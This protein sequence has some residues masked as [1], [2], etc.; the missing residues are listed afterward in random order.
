MNLIRVVSFICVSICFLNHSN[1]QSNL[2][3]SFTHGGITREYKIY[4]PASYTGQAVPLVLNI[5]GYG[6]DMTQ[7]EAY[8][9]FKPIADSASFIIVHPNGT[10]DASLKRY[11]NFFGFTTVDDLGFLSALIDTVKANYNID[12]NRIYSTGMSNGGIMSYYLACNLSG[13]IA[14]I[15]SVTGTMTPAMES[16]CNALHPTPAMQIHGTADPVVPYGGNGT[17]I[18]IDS[19]VK[20]W[21]SFNN[22]S[23]TPVVTN[24]PNTNTSDGCTATRYDYLNGTAG[25]KVVFYK[26]TGGGHTWPGAPV[27]VGVT[28]HDFDA[29]TEI[30]K[31]F[32]GYRLN[33]LTGL[34]SFSKEK[35]LSVYPNPASDHVIISSDEENLDV[36]IYDVLSKVVLRKSIIKDEV[37][38][39]S[40]L[41]RGTY[42]L[43]VMS[44][45][46]VR[47]VT[48]VK[49]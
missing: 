30:W 49:L 39:I 20:F 35:T 13:K 41:K 1:A 5:H 17:F 14:A 25:S 19:V 4:I 3:K 37:I 48:L 24:V 45:D 43:Q 21:R 26:I 9:N 28:N 16:G 27:D 31:F 7:Q 36:V 12:Q 44:D 40:S 29:S 47:S 34:K 15:A 2:T 32:R 18:P 8:G 42:F 10:Y 46:Q 33:E 23:S 38:D 22:C 6:S 11:W